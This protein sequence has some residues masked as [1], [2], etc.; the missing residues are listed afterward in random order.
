[1]ASNRPID[2]RYVAASKGGKPFADG[3]GDDAPFSSPEGQY[4]MQWVIPALMKDVAFLAETP[5]PS[6]AGLISFTRDL[7]FDGASAKA[8]PKPAFAIVRDEMFG[9]THD[10][11]EWE[12]SDIKPPHTVLFGWV[13]TEDSMA[14]FTKVIPVISSGCAFALNLFE[15]GEQ[16]RVGIWN[17]MDWDMKLR[18]PAA[19]SSSNAE[20]YGQRYPV[21]WMTIP[22]YSRRHALVV[23]EYNDVYGA[24]RGSDRREGFEDLILNGADKYVLHA[25]NSLVYGEYLDSVV[26]DEAELEEALEILAMAFHLDPDNEFG[27]AQATNAL[28]NAGVLYYQA[29][30]LDLAERTLLHALERAGGDDEDSNGDEASFVLSLVYEELGE[31][32]KADEYREMSEELGGYSSAS[33]LRRPRV[34]PGKTNGSS[35]GRKFCTNCGQAFLKTDQKFC[36]GCGTK[37]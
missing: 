18:Q 14:E 33:K 8:R 17:G 35:S 23:E 26:S 1:L 30:K 16:E 5:F 6:T 9:F 3:L 10:S 22:E 25:A 36:S 19:L 15:E 20:K 11:A 4:N 24:E 29:G 12:F 34:N 21:E 37:N 28:S 27:D 2:Y 13:L 31:S 32:D 7:A